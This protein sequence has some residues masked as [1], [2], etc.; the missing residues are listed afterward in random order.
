MLNAAVK[1]DNKLLAALNKVQYTREL[2]QKALKAY[3]N[4]FTQLLHLKKVCKKV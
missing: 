3:L 2:K 1:L 4:A